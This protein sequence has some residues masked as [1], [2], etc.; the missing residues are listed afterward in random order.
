MNKVGKMSRF[1]F[2][3]G[4]ITAMMTVLQTRSFSQPRSRASETEAGTDAMTTLTPFLLFDGNCKEAME[5]YKTCF[6]GELTQM[7][8]GD[9]PAKEF[10]PAYQHP[11]IIN[12]RL[13]SG[14]IDISATDWLRPDEKRIQGNSVCLYLDAGSADELQSLFQRLSVG[15]D[16]T[17]PLKKMFFG[18]YGAL[19]DKFGVRWMFHSN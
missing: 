16:V 18:T 5:F 9:S 12:A 15:A 19:N 11:K 10:M 8:V 3:V 17:D 2:V 7:K 13:K 1:G 4:A 14:N 6:G